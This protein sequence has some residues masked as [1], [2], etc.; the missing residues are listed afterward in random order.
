MF[1]R[2]K[3]YV[4]GLATALL[5]TAC[6]TKETI[7]QVSILMNQSGWVTGGLLI[8]GPRNLMK[9]STNTSPDIPS[10]IS[11]EVTRTPTPGTQEALGIL[12][13][14]SIEC[15]SKYNT[16]HFNFEDTINT[17]R[18][19]VESSESV[20]SKT[21]QT[22]SNPKL[23]EI[24]WVNAGRC[25]EGKVRV[26]TFPW[27][28]GVLFITSYAQGTLGVPVNNEDIHLVVQ[29][30][31]RDG[32]YA[33]NGHFKI[34]HPN[35]PATAWDTGRKGLKIFSIDDEAKLA[36]KWLDQQPDD[37]FSPSFQQYES[38]LQGLEF[39]H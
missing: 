10:G 7:P 3:L 34:N 13:I 15:A 5:L 38:M 36:E 4:S 6:A 30:L 37:S 33:I 12:Q 21:R 20:N 32:R 31:S 35:L 23:N 16:K 24:P 19:I 25:F 17:W 11:I 2:I 1:T 9:F 14:L 28:K 22:L 29:G 39:K 27:G 26:R 8:H 18:T